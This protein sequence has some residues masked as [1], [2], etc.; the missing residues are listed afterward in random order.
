MISLQKGFYSFIYRKPRVPRFSALGDYSEDELVA[1]RKEQAGIERF[2]H[3]NPTYKIEKHSTLS[4]Y[5]DALGDQ[6]FRQLYKFTC[7]RNPSDWMVSY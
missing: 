7:I 3:R 1:L 6:Q 2:G 5:R 4:E